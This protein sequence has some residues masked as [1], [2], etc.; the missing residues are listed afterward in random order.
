MRVNYKVNGQHLK[1]YT[2]NLSSKEIEEAIRLY[3]TR[4]IQE[5]VTDVEL[6]TYLP[7]PKS[8]EGKE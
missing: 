3:L 6:R 2:H 8:A 7:L 1:M 5:E 4:M